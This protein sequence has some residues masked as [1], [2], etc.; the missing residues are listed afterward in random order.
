MALMLSLTNEFY[1]YAVGFEATYA[2]A[3]GGGTDYATLNDSIGSD[4]FTGRS[5]YS[6]MEDIGSTYRNYASGFDGVF[7][8]STRGGTDSANLHDAVANDT[9]FGR[10]DYCTLTGGGYLNRATGFSL[11]N[12]YRLYC[13]ESNVDVSAVDYLFDDMG[14]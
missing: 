7:A 5:T 14:A 13:G 2:Y 10:D 11:V 9:I 12:L 1:N 4:I 8:Y 3:T 6:V